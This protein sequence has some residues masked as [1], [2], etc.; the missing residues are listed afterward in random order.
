MRGA[1]VSTYGHVIRGLNTPRRQ[2]LVPGYWV[3][4]I[5]LQQ[6]VK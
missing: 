1:S 5:L 2:T 6:Y 4:F 3:P